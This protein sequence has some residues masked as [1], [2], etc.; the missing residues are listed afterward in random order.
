MLRSGPW[1]CRC[2]DSHSAAARALVALILIPK[3][4]I[5]LGGI[6]CAYKARVIHLPEFNEVQELAYAF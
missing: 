5:V 6:V 2:G 3:V 4:L 1:L